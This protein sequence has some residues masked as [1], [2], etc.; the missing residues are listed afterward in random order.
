MTGKPDKYRDPSKTKLAG[1]FQTQ[2]SS[3]RVQFL[4]E[5]SPN[6]YSNRGHDITLK[7][8]SQFLNG[9]VCIGSFMAPLRAGG[10]QRQGP[11]RRLRGNLK[12]PCPCAAPS[13]CECPSVQACTIVMKRCQVLCCTF[14][15]VVV[16]Q[17]RASAR[18]GGGD[19]RWR[20]GGHG[21]GTHEYDSTSLVIVLHQ[22][23]LLYC[24]L[25]SKPRACA[26]ACF[27]STS[28]AVS[29]RSPHHVNPLASRRA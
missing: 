13:I 21:R 14:K 25:Y 24:K 19:E 1:R 15:S 7:Y 20:T 11:T 16:S 10:L 4:R 27:C 12:S 5:S 26:H 18:G 17:K 2:V 3:R 28:A 9:T 23:N 29:H 22:R 8:E 6:E